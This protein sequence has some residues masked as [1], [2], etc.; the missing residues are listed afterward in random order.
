MYPIHHQ[1]IVIPFN[2]VGE[3][4]DRWFSTGKPRHA[5]Y[6]VTFADGAD[7][8]CGSD[9]LKTAKKGGRNAVQPATGSDRRGS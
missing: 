1:V 4:T 5:T 9:Q 6:L 8:V 2:E 7:Y 3:V